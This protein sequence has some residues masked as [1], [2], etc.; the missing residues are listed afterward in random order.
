MG[1]VVARINRLSVEQWD[2]ITARLLHT[3]SG[4]LLPLLLTVA[5]L[6]T[7]SECF[8]LNWN[9]EWQG[10]NVADKASGASGDIT[11]SRNGQIQLAIEITE[12]PI[13]RAR[14]ISIFNTKISP[15]A[16]EDYIFAFTNAAPTL[17]VRQ[18]A[19][20]LFGQGHE[21]NFVELRPWLVNNLTTVGAQCRAGFGR[22]FT[23]LLDQPTVPAALK[24]T[25]NDLVK[26]VVR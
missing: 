21:V 26:E 11:V 10:I 24:V 12:R 14:V 9:I 19:R 22:H 16:V 1:F 5:M 18:Y 25:W 23:S 15:L 4:G 13:D 8:E 17:D 6:Q 7:I 20:L 3:P 2:D